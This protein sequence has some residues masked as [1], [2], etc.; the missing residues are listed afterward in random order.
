MW[1]G[2]FRVGRVYRVIL[3]VGIPGDEPGL[4][5]SGLEGS[6]EGGIRLGESGG[7]P[8]VGVRRGI[9]GIGTGCPDYGLG[10]VVPA[11]DWDRLSQLRSGEAVPATLGSAGLEDRG[12]SD[13]SDCSGEHF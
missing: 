9:S 3:A 10:Q 7:G 4:I 12:R 13:R 2:I 6:V 5:S 1:Q 11:T 8:G